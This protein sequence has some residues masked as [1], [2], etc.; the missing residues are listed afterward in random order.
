MTVIVLIHWGSTH[1]VTVGGVTAGMNLAYTPV[2]TIKEEGII[3]REGNNG[4]QPHELTTLAPHR[5]LRV[6][7]GA[8][9]KHQL[10]LLGTPGVAGT[11]IRK[12]TPTNI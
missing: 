11:G 2:Q 6:T 4:H 1:F 5:G 10:G 8:I 7:P 3:I 9:S 12:E